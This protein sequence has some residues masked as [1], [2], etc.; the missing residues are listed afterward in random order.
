[1]MQP[2][3]LKNSQRSTLLLLLRVAGAEKVNDLY[4]GLI[5]S[6]TIA[7]VWHLYPEPTHDSYLNTTHHNLWPHEKTFLI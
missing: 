7:E 4:I 5:V 1:M 3:L 2:Y 6:F